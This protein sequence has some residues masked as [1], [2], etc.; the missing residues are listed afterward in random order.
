MSDFS[1]P[2]EIDKVEKNKFLHLY[3]PEFDPASLKWFSREMYEANLD[4]TSADTTVQ[5]LRLLIKMYSVHVVRHTKHSIYTRSYEYNTANRV[6][7]AE[8]VVKDMGFKLVGEHLDDHA[9]ANDDMLVLLFDNG[10]VN[11]FSYSPLLNDEVYEKIKDLFYVPEKPEPNTAWTIDAS[12][13]GYEFRSHTIKERT[14]IEENYDPEV[15]A[16]LP[17][18]YDVVNGE[19]PDGRLAV[20]EGPPGGGKSNL[21]RGLMNKFPNSKFVWVPPY[22]VPNIASPSMFSSVL[23]FQERDQRP[24]VLLLEDADECLKSREDGSTTN[25]SQVLNLADGLFTDSVDIRLV[26]TTN[27]HKVKM[28][29]AV[30]RNGRMGCYISINDLKWDQAENIYRR[31]MNDENATLPLNKSK[32][33]MLA[34]VYAAT[35]EINNLDCDVNA[36]K[37]VVGF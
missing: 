7:I 9:F 6:K 11:T 13:G 22:L 23:R 37:R 29:N 4:L 17:K 10:Y 36:P 12:G 21:I 34:D 18:L 25:I 27:L 31:L 24:L 2:E 20:L 3:D 30:T 32:P 8:R 33:V 14:L 26:A 28:D 15:V 1:N 5:V 35:K 19:D 16:Q